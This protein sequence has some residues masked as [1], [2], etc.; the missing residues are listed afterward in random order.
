MDWI[1]VTNPYAGPTPIYVPY[2]PGSLRPE[3]KEALDY[4][5]ERV[6]YV[7]VSSD[8]EAYW[9]L[10]KSLWQKYRDFIVVEQDILIVPGITLESFSTCPVSLCVSNYRYQ[11][12]NADLYG[13]KASPG[14]LGGLGCC[15]FR[16]RVMRHIPNAI[17]HAGMLERAYMGNHPPRHWCALDGAIKDEL[18]MWGVYPCGDHPVSQHLHNETSH[19]CDRRG[20]GPGIKFRGVYPLGEA[21]W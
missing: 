12:A 21:P 8:D 2:V 10:V 20:E 7:D 6:S 15:R 4:Y 18:W 14:W 1:A 17:D 9:R 16:R 5:G 11:N 13:G 3:V 19:G